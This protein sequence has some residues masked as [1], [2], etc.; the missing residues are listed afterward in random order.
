MN[1]QQKRIKLVLERVIKACEEDASDAK[2]WSEWIDNVCE[3]LSEEDFFGTEGQSDP[4]GDQRDNSWT[5]W[6]VEGID[7]PSGR[8]DD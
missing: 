8:D 6:R 2:V 7:N 4:R 5:M 1:K 3:Y